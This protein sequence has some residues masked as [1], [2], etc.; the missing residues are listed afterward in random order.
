MR[1]TN[2]STHCFNYK[3]NTQA[4]Y[5]TYSGRIGKFGYQIGLRGEY[6]NVKTRSYGWEQE[7]KGEI[8]G[9][10]SNSFFKLFPSAFISYEIGDGQEIQMNYTRRLRRPWGGQLNNFQNI[11]DSTN[12]SFG[13]PNL[14]PEYSNAYELNYL[15]NWENHTLSLSGYY[16]TTDDVIERI[17]YG[18][19]TGRVIYTTFEN[20]T[21]TQSAGLE[22]VSKNRLFKAI[23]LTTTV[24][25]FYYKLNAFEYVINGQPITGKA[26]ENFSWNARMTANI[27]LPWGITMQATGRYDAKRIVAQGYREP[28]YSLDL[29]LR[30]MFNQ[31]WSLS[32]NA[33]DILDSRGRKTITSNDSFY[34]YSENSHGGRRF[35]FT[36]T[37]SFGNMKAKMPKRKQ[38]EMPSSGYSEMDGMG[39]M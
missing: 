34:R 20:V 39:E 13:N 16:R 21:Q 9:Y 23:D 18:S 10:T 22:I 31:H 32:I 14:T 26:D 17:S 3:Q 30:K 7:Q 38:Q 6:W 19:G 25:L 8:P 11:S 36:L 28:S 35:G 27:M 29:G 24:N 37:Y 15:K 5:A 4:L 12:I 33:R 2:N 1:H